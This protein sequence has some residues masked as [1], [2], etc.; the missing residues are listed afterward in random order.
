VTSEHVDLDPVLAADLTVVERL[1]AQVHVLRARADAFRGPRRG[2]R[3]LVLAMRA[4]NLEEV[5]LAELGVE[6][7]A[8]VMAEME[9]H[10][11][12][13]AA[14]D[15]W[16]YALRLTERVMQSSDDGPDQARSAIPEQPG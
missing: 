10:A 4:S 5:V 12:T 16:L 3:S 15:R 13:R 8:R 9:D 6:E 1:A 11:A 2:E 7:G 14:I